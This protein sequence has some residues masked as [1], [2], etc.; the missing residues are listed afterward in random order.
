M[1]HNTVFHIFIVNCVVVI[2]IIV[3]VV[4]ANM[5]ILLILQ[6]WYGY[7]GGRLRGGG[8]HGLRVDPTAGRQRQQWRQCAGPICGRNRVK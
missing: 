2:I 1:M 7:A 3:I 8:H 5:I 6:I 4:A